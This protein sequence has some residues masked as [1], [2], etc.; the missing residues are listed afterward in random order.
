MPHL[1]V[2]ISAHGFGHLAQTAAVLNALEMQDLRITIR[3]QAPLSLLRE[4]IQVGF[5]LLPYQQDNG[6]LML[7]ALQVDV[8]KSLAWYQNFHATF[9]ERVEQAAQEL[10]ALQADL[11]LVNVPYL[12]LAA[13]QSLNLPS[14]A[15]CSLNWA[16]VFQSY[17][18]HLPGSAEIHAEILAAYQGVQCFLQPTPSMPMINLPR[19]RVLAPIVSLGNQQ[20]ERLTAATNSSFRQF[21]LV[22]LGGIGIHYPLETWPKLAGVA[23]IFDDKS[24]YRRREDFFPVSSFGLSYID[25]LASCNLVLTK[26]GYGTQT[27]AVINQIPALCVQRPDWP[28]EPYLSAWHQQQGEVVF[29]DWQAIQTGQFVEPLTALLTTTWTK[30][31]VL[32]TGAQ[33]AASYIQACLA[34]K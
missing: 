34:G 5:E 7:D 32:P 30:Q 4:R 13:A 10:A 24:L 28:E 9:A 26:T 27:E 21:I 33:E 3:S 18:G 6:M 29:I 19:T 23:W 20:S 15:L 25:L 1:V 8:P 16:D 14:L 12:S 2:D 22:S 17:C 11:L 31:R